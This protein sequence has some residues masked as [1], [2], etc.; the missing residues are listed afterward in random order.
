MT[1]IVQYF[2]K[3]DF[4]SALEKLTDKIDCA[5]SAKLPTYCI[6][7]AKGEQF[8][9]HKFQVMIRL[10]NSIAESELINPNKSRTF[11]K[12]FMSVAWKDVNPEADEAVVVEEIIIPEEETVV[13]VEEVVKVDAPK[14]PQTKAPKK[15]AVKK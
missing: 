12:R 5:E 4:F 7:D 10:I 9:C 14:K 11:R 1:Q 8:L 6:Q 13:V 2:T 3:A 15:K